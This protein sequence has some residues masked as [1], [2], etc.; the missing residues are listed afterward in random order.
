MVAFATTS[1]SSTPS[2]G[3]RQSSG[4]KNT[5][6]KKD[7]FCNFCKKPGHLAKSCFTKKGAR[8]TNKS[9]EN[10]S[11]LPNPDSAQSSAF[12][13]SKKPQ[14]ADVN[15]SV[16]SYNSDQSSVNDASEHRLL[17]SAASQH[18]SYRRK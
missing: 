8:N 18:I 9:V 12:V 11:V 16:P 14:A 13:V 6:N 7:R 5:R 15:I 4:D 1:I 2:G 17:D 3:Q 10:N